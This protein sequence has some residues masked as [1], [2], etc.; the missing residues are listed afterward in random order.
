MPLAP[1]FAHTPVIP[2]PAYPHRKWGTYAPGTP[3][4]EIHGEDIVHEFGILDEEHTFTKWKIVKDDVKE[5]INELFEEEVDELWKWR[6]RYNYWVRKI[7]S[8]G[9]SDIENLLVDEKIFDD[10]FEAYVKEG[11]LKEKLLEVRESILSGGITNTQKERLIPMLVV[12]VFLN[13]RYG[14]KTESFTGSRQYDIFSILDKEVLQA[15]MYATLERIFT[16]QLS[17]TID[18]CPIDENGNIVMIAP[19]DD[20]NGPIKPSELEGIAPTTLIKTWAIDKVWNNGV[21]TVTTPSSNT[22]FQV[23]TTHGIKM[24][25]GDTNEVMKMNFWK[26]DVEIEDIEFSDIEE[27][28]ST[29]TKFSWAKKLFDTVTW[30][31]RHFQTIH[32]VTVWGDTFTQENEYIVTS[33]AWVTPLTY[34]PVRTLVGTRKWWKMK[35]EHEGGYENTFIRVENEKT[36]YADEDVKA[37]A[38]SLKIRTFMRRVKT[39]I[40]KIQ[41]ISLK[42]GTGEF[43]DMP[44][45]Y[46]NM[47][48]KLVIPKDG[49]L[50]IFHPSNRVLTEAM[51]YDIGKSI[52]VFTLPIWDSLSHQREVLV[53][54]IIN[55]WK[56]WDFLEV[57]YNTLMAG[58]DNI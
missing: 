26:W 27:T 51:I 23:Y 47:H 41:D 42:R 46:N 4:Q 32:Y 49:T 17:D 54:E 20:D 39:L 2:P 19:Q 31:K 28:S 13:A 57:Y 11:K 43:N 25:N 16:E 1:R 29:K 37:L 35:L 6:A 10:R 36:A 24:M 58:L 50:S 48:G 9:K 33:A 21:D 30:R 22:F 12:A 34:R 56:T 52:G 8:L 53:A 40:K 38:E 7:F 5:R 15:P 45:R 44:L 3:V 14:A 55:Q 18:I